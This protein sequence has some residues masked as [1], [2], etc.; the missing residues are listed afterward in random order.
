MVCSLHF[1]KLGK[2]HVKHANSHTSIALSMHAEL[3]F[4][5][6]AKSLMYASSSVAEQACQRC[7]LCMLPF[8]R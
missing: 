3:A 5:G 1:L 6:T 8:S 2:K 7:Q 4:S